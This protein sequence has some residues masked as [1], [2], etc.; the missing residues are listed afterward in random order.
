MKIFLDSMPQT[1]WK[2]IYWVR[3]AGE[4]RRELVHQEGGSGDEGM[5][6]KGRGKGAREGRGDEG[7]STQR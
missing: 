6:S 5:Y 2:N 1:S 3:L 4:G 7:T